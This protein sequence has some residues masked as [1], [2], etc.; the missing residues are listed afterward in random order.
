MNTDE[1]WA[2]IDAQRVR[3]VTLLQELTPAE[4][5]QAS[6]CEAWRVRDVVAHL[7][8]QPITL[9]DALWSMVRHP[10]SLTK[11]SIAQAIREANRRPPEQLIARLAATVGSRRHNIG[12]TE[13]E[14]LIEIIVHGQDVAVPLER[15]LEVPPEAAAAAARHFSA[16]EASRKGRWLVALLFR[17]VPLRSYRLTATDIEWSAGEGL[18]IRGPILAILLLLTGR[19][20][21]FFDLEGPG[22]AA[23]GATLGLTRD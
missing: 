1:L 20:A 2:A 5:D 14:T 15:R 23:L 21:R 22:A 12:V 17:R 3:T 18:E 10:G 11:A 19:T 4:W 16:Y 13:R 7:S 9:R 6:L 8:L